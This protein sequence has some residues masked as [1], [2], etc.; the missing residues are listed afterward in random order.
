MRGASGIAISGEA[1]EFDSQSAV[2]V[3]AP[4]AF[5]RTMRTKTGGAV[6]TGD[7]RRH[8]CPTCRRASSWDKED[9]RSSCSV[10]TSTRTARGIGRWVNQ[11]HCRSKA[12][13]S[14]VERKWPDADAPGS[15]RTRCLDLC[16]NQAQGCLRRGGVGQTTGS[17]CHSTEFST[18]LAYPKWCCPAYPAS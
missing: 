17:G 8:D 15:F 18:G 12:Q 2:A 7:R 4:I 5:H 9:R 11:S 1:S 16:E 13:C 3:S 10:A 6:E 14:G